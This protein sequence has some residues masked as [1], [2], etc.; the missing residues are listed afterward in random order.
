MP[1]AWWNSRILQNSRSRPEKANTFLFRTKV[2]CLFETL[3]RLPGFS[4]FCFQKSE[5]LQNCRILKIHLLAH[6]D[7]GPLDLFLEK[8]REKEVFWNPRQNPVAT[9][10]VYAKSSMLHPKPCHWTIFAQPFHIFVRKFKKCQIPLIWATKL[11]FGQFLLETSAK[12]NSPKQP[13]RACFWPWI[14]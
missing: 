9:L 14:H 8:K 4:F 10:D 13:C 5:H 7:Q 3:G 2:S 11:N 12:I 1:V 6:P